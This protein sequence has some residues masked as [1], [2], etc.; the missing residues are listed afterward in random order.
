MRKADGDVSGDEQIPR[1]RLRRLGKIVGMSTR[2]GAGLVSSGAR[3]LRGEEGDPRLDA[4]RKV[5]DTLGELKGAALKVGQTMALISDQ[6]PPE[7]RAII[8]QLFSQAPTL[9]FEEIARVIEQELGRPPGELFAEL[10]PTP[11]AGASLG[12]VHRA[13]LFS[14]E[15]VAV[16]VQYPGV[17]SALEAD[18]RNVQSVL[19]AVG[20]GSQLLDTR[21]YFDEMR[22][23]ITAELDYRRE[24]QNLEEFRGYLGRWPDLVVPRAYPQLCTGKVLV[25][26]RLE[27]PTLHEYARSIE[28][29]PPPVR[30]AVAERLSRAI[31][32]PFVY[33]RVI[34]GDAHPG[35]FVVMEGDRLGV[36]DYGS[37]KHLSKRFWSAYL[38]GFGAAL[39]GRQVYLPTLL[40]GAGFVLDLP[41]ERAAQL[42]DAV[43]QIVGA[44]LAGPY[45][46]SRDTMVQQMMGLRARYALD[47]LR[48]RVPPEALLFYRAIAGLGHDLRSLKA[49]GDFRPF[50]RTALAASR[51]KA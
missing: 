24:L 9:P 35:N 43:A 4:A 14:G 26:E 18:L 50:L 16:K 45:D 5:L 10:E 7:A 31:L 13:R 36:L 17:D 33:H 30:F 12:Q 1:G 21:E 42:L 44:P 47:F 19:R 28:R 34:H 25:L 22:R 8:S 51:R 48:I 32:G 2:V 46:W 38:E 41:E 29:V 20:L 37:A 6:L 11:F 39:E 3:R 49:A 27:G 15:E 23:E 40:R